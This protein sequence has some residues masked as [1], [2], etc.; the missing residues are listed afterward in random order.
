MLKSGRVVEDGSPDSLMR[1][2]GAYYELV[3]R[4]MNRLTMRVA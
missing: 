4:E 1:R 3:C 2:K